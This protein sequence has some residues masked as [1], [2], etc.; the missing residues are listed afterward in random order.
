MDFSIIS[1]AISVGEAVWLFLVGWGEG[2]GRVG[3]G[4]SARDFGNL[5]DLHG[6]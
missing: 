6:R 2:G 5:G 1:T 3:V 4:G